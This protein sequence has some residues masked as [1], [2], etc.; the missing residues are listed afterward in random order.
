MSDGKIRSSRRPV[1]ATNGVL[2]ET[3]QEP[4]VVEAEQAG[5]V[6]NGSCGQSGER[7]GRLSGGPVRLRG[8]DSN[9]DY[10]IQSQASYH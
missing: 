1:H 2:D 9:L 6:T 7:K 4:A 10:L 5:P 8:K 3:G